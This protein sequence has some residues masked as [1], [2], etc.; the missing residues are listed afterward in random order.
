M[1]HYDLEEQEQL[2]SIKTWWKMYGNLVTGLVAAVSL[3][4]VGWQGWNWYKADVSGKA[5]LVFSALE[6]AVAVKDAPRIKAAA[7]ELTEKFSGSHYAALGALVAAKA[8]VDSGD[9]KTAKLQ[10]SWVIDNDKGELKDLAR[11]RLAVL[12]LDENAYDDAQ[13]LLEASHASAFNPRFSE[14]KGEV[15]MA[16]GKKAE[17]RLAFKAAIASLEERT[18]QTAAPGKSPAETQGPYREM[19]QQKLDALGEVA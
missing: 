7:G 6:D 18:A 8:S 15:L 3:A 5:S 4:V 14:L 10:L 12:L 17:A 9:T 11:L 16:Q 13:K 19:L 1:A 2:D